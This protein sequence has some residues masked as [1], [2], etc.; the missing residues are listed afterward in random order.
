MYQNVVTYQCKD[1]GKTEVFRL[2]GQFS[3]I[4]NGVIE[5]CFNEK[6]CMNCYCNKQIPATA[7]A[8]QSF[9]VGK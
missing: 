5:K 3:A 2:P 1:C 4:Q 8:I 7:E 9:L 6:I